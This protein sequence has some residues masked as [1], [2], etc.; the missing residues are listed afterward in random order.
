MTN[1]NFLN[2]IIN[3]FKIIFCLTITCGCISADRNPSNGKVEKDST[4]LIA[5]N[6]LNEINQTYLAW[7]EAEIEA[8][9]IQIKCPEYGS[10][11]FQK[12]IDSDYNNDNRFAYSKILRKLYE[13]FNQ[14]GIKDALY[15][16]EK[17]D[18]VV[19]NGY[20]GDLQRGVIILSE[21]EDFK[22]DNTIVKKLTDQINLKANK[23]VFDT[24]AYIEIQKANNTI[25]YG[26]YWD[27]E[28]EDPTG[29]PS[30]KK[31]FEYNYLVDK[32]K[33]FN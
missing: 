20:V 21:K 32:L 27:W 31:N 1:N 14:D 4:K 25:I 22:V 18:C 8:N 6:Y 19:G 16:L 10:E 12:L 29:Q 2:L 17:Q 5:K 3:F 9:R 33:V 24:V 11:E 13:D 15:V 23:K 7:L 28:S 26:S 30:I